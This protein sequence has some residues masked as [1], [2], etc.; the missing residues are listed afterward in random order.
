MIVD[1][2]KTR[3]NAFIY[4][5]V[6]LLFFIIIG[7]CSVIINMQIKLRGQLKEIKNTVESIETEIF[8]GYSEKV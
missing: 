7:F 2:K 4:F 3:S 8:T 6:S 1:R 5:F